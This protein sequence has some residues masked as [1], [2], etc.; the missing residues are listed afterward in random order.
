MQNQAENGILTLSIGKKF[1]KQAKYLAYSCILNSPSLPRAI[2][3][4]NTEYFIGIYDIIIQ[5]TK[6]MGDPFYVKLKL[7]EHSPWFKTLFLDSDTLVYTDLKFLFDYFGENSIVWRGGCRKEG[8]WYFNEMADVIKYY[9]I[10]FIGKFNSGIFLFK[11]DETGINVMNYAAELHKN[12]GEGGI[13]VPYFRQKYLPDEPFLGVAFGK[14]GQLPVNDYGRLG[15][16][17][18]NSKKIKLDIIKG[19]ANF[20]K[21]GSQMFCAAVHFKGK[22]Y[23]YPK[24]KYKLFMHYYNIP[25]STLIAFPVLIFSFCIWFIKKCIKYIKKRI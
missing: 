12:N 6:E 8:K 11:K 18:I 2:I 1:N 19:I 5:Y 9:N 21:N 15:R 25:G 7:H 22:D 17:L 23:Y 10:P 13:S 24:E 4:D 14:Y 16:T 20:E 3:T